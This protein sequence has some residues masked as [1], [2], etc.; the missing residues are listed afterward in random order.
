MY[1]SIAVPTAMS[2][3]EL[4]RQTILMEKQNE[5]LAEQNELMGRLMNKISPP[6]NFTEWSPY[7]DA[8]ESHNNTHKNIM[9]N[10]SQS[11]WVSP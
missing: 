2:A 7:G 1:Q 4:R 3:M 6:T 5:L 9:W 11:G 8:W 10:K